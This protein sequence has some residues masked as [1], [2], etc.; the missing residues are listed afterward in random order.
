[1]NFR[2]TAV[3]FAVV[4]A[5]VV[6]LLL[7]AALS[8]DPSVPADGPFAALAT[9]GVKADA[10][11]T[12]EITR[13]GPP[14]QTL[15]F[16]KADGVWRLTRPAA[17]PV[18]SPAL[19]ELVRELLALKSA[20]YTGPMER[21]NTGLANPEVTVTLRAG[22]KSAGVHLGNTTVGKEQAVTFMVSADDPNARPMAVF[23][24]GFRNSL[25]RPGAT[26]G[27]ASALVKGRTDF[28]PAAV[29][30]GD[31]RDPETEV[32][33]VAV[34]RDGKKLA[35]A[36]T[37]AGEWRFTTPDL[38]AADV[39]G[40]SE[41][42]PA[43]YTGVRPLLN[44]VVSLRI[45]GPAD[46]T[47]DVPAADLSKYGLAPADRPLKV[48][49]TPKGKPAQT[50]LVGKRVTDKDG[51]SVLPPRQYVKLDGD[52]AVFAVG[53]DLADKLGATL[54]DPSPL[55]NR[56]LL[57]PAKLAQIDAVDST[58]GGGFALRKLGGPNDPWALYGGG[59]PAEA[60]AQA[61][62]ALLNK[63]SAQRVAV[64]VLPADNAAFAGANLQGELKVWFGGVDKAKARVGADGKLP[65][66][67]ATAGEPVTLRFGLTDKK[68]PVVRR[69]SG[70]ESTDFEVAKEVAD[71][72]LQPRIKFVNARPPS[73][74]PAQANALVLFRNAA[75]TEYV[76]NGAMTDPAYPAGLW[77]LGD[78]KG[79]VADGDTVML[80]LT[81]L[82]AV[83][84]ALIAE[85][86]DDPKG[87]GLD[88]ANPRLSARVSVPG[89]R[90]VR[91][92]EYLFGE[93]VKGDDKSVY[94]QAVGKPFVYAVPAE[95]AD[96]LRT[97]DLSDKVAFRLDPTRVKSLQLRGWRGGPEQ[98][99]MKV[100]VERQNGRWVVT[101]PKDG[102]VEQG[103]VDAWLDA[104][105][106]P[107]GVGP[108]P[109]E[110]GK[111]PP[112]AYGLGAAEA[113][114]LTV[115]SRGEKEGDKDTAVSLTFG[116]MNADRTGVYARRLGGKVYLLDAR[117]FGP[118]LATPP[119]VK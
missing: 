2:L 88:P 91:T 54:A 19:D 25:F 13:P 18:S 55:R 51:K 85:K 21:T 96:R 76:K 22:D 109:V 106:F 64:N 41:P 117:P 27:K 103:L 93:K 113:I 89:E 74:V 53:T 77:N 44:A 50:V 45:T 8:P 81:R 33:A 82:A 60:Q 71:L 101:D 69:V 98:Q 100:T 80:L 56:D 104:V 73:F 108:A 39:N 46:V 90:G 20:D 105:R 32:E 5:L 6:G 24:K 86:A 94:F 112:A 92:E 26:D 61:V 66:Q 23:T 16:V 28:R 37:P 83:P 10:V 99:Q 11:T 59:E 107:K 72:A 102:R 68:V 118:L 62:Q 79:P 1:M 42:D 48:T 63:L 34:E 17:A 49:V 114:D 87:M 4:L 36:R 14:E 40:A 30:A 31:V 119:L 3:L 67:P 116:A 65:P 35:L 110:E 47:E 58:A 70:K 115:V 97:A 52:A 57:P 15:V 9:A 75:R 78:A 7:Y 12:V 43:R 29:L 111:D 84:A 95:L 38:G